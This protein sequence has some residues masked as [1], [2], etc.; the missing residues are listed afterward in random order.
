MSLKQLTTIFCSQEAMHLVNQM[1]NNTY[2]HGVI[3][4]PDG[5]AATSCTQSDT[6]ANKSL[7]QLEATLLELAASPQLCQG[8]VYMFPVPVQDKYIIR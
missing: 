2:D 1:E 5:S 6:Y 7:I 3:Y 8:V 4:I